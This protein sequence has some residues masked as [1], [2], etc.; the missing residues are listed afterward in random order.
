MATLSTLLRQSQIVQ[1]EK[2]KFIDEDESKSKSLKSKQLKGESPAS[3]WTCESK[4][5]GGCKETK[6]SSVALNE[7]KT[8]YWNDIETCN[9]N[10]GLSED[11]INEIGT[12]FSGGKMATSLR[13]TSNMLRN[14]EKGQEEKNEQQ[15]LRLLDDYLRLWEFYREQKIGYR[16]SEKIRKDI[17]ERMTEMF[18]LGQG[19]DFYNLVLKKILTAGGNLSIVNTI[20]FRRLEL[21]LSKLSRF[22]NIDW[23]DLLKFA[24]DSSYEKEEKEVTKDIMFSL[25]FL[26]GFANE[27]SPLLIDEFFRKYPEYLGKSTVIFDNYLKNNY[28]SILDIL[29]LD[30]EDPLELNFLLYSSTFLRYYLEKS[31]FQDIV[32]IGRF[33]RYLNEEILML[34]ESKPTSEK[35]ESVLENIKRYKTNQVILETL[36][37]VENQEST[38]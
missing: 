11:L 27:A 2:R 30:E 16:E 19:K 32:S 18:K 5:F 3:L 20:P 12:E 35:T 23:I 1:G 28:N 22:E 38:F 34:Y 9:L 29:E 21:Q 36:F 4:I 17:L 37:P 26:F 7:K 31:K 10:C 8:P 6:E 25:I 15:L 14:L 33:S 24:I 13:G